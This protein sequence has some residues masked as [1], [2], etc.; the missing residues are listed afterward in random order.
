[1]D[2]NFYP[3]SFYTIRARINCK[4]VFERM[5]NMIKNTKMIQFR[6]ITD[7]HNQ[8][9]PMGHLTPIESNGDVPFDINRVYYM[10][11]V[12]ENTTRGF[13]SHREL[14]QVLICLNGTV[15]IVVSTPYEKET[16]TLKDPSKGLYI[17][18]MVWREMK[19]FSA[20]SVLMVLASKHYDEKDYIRD[21]DQYI[22]EAKE[23]FKGE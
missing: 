13:H 8:T 11:R 19:D 6:D 20:G 5:R 10:T 12:P 3:F 18:P 22:K 4:I 14:E 21:Y 15:D 9:R 2:G 16:I 17:G 7:V 1:M 23:Y